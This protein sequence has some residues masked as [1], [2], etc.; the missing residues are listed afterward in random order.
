MTR[1]CTGDWIVYERYVDVEKHEIG[2]RNTQKIER[3]YLTNYLNR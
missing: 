1:D 2:K 3:K